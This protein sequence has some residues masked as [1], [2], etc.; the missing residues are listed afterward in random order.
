MFVLFYEC[1][2]SEEV[3]WGSESEEVFWVWGSVLKCSGSEWLSYF[4]LHIHGPLMVHGPLRFVFTKCSESEEVFWV[5]L[6]LFLEY[7]YPWTAKCLFLFY[8]VFWVFQTNGPWTTKVFYKVFWDI[9]GL[10]GSHAFLAPYTQQT[11]TWTYC[12]H[13]I[14]IKLDPTPLVSLFFMRIIFKN[15]KIFFWK[16]E[17]IKNSKNVMKKILFQKHMIFAA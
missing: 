10:S 13:M 2:E 11:Q 16:I 14:F 9:Q 8:E 1:S 12:S 3:F 5:A 7:P 4:F 15:F 17:K 6:I